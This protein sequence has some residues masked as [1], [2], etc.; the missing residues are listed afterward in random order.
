MN[1]V[2]MKKIMPVIAIAVI[3]LS[4]IYMLPGSASAH[5]LN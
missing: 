3:L 5:R 1:E 4:A 2:L